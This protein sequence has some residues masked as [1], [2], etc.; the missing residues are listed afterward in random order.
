MYT[1]QSYK[2]PS[3]SVVEGSADLAEHGVRRSGRLGICIGICKIN[4][5]IKML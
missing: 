4:V 3:V 5:I 2:G 1:A